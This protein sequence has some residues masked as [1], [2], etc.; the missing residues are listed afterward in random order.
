VH[1]GRIGRRGWRV[2]A[3]LALLYGLLTLGAIT[4][5]YPFALMLSTAT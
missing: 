2:R 3:G 5:L 4:T 1:I